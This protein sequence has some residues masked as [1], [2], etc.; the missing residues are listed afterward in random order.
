MGPL[1]LLGPKTVN[2][3]SISNF[4]GEILVKR[5]LIHCVTGSDPTGAAPNS[6]KQ[7]QGIV[8]FHPNSLKK[9]G[10][11]GLPRVYVLSIGS[12]NQ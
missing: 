10:Y 12:N 11:P 8:C 1:M 6:D 3:S 2:Y 4:R 5:N 7:K 9:L